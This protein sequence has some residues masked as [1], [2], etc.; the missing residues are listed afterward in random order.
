[1]LW[2][3]LVLLVLAGLALSV[4]PS[5][6]AEKEERANVEKWQSS[7]A[8]RT[9]KAAYHQARITK[10]TRELGKL[11]RECDATEESLTR[12]FAGHPDLAHE[13]REALSWR[14][15]HRS[16]A[17]NQP[18]GKRPPRWRENLEESLETLVHESN[19]LQGLRALGADDP[20][21]GDELGAAI[22]FSC[23]V[24]GVRAADLEDNEPDAPTTKPLV[25]KAREAVA[26]AQGLVPA[27]TGN[28]K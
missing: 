24:V 5:Y 26:K 18:R 1:M 15:L 7:A 9:Y 12:A 21:I 2:Q 16:R 8:W 22:R 19:A 17:L 27:A 20:W 11:E 3:R 14:I 6:A 28:A 4:G 23:E 10:S 25:T 13:L